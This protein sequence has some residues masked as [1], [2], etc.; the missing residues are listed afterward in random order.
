MANG[1]QALAESAVRELMKTIDWP[2]FYCCL[3]LGGGVKI[4]CDK[5]GQVLIDPINGQGPK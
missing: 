4:T 2:R 1:A 5:D 3:I